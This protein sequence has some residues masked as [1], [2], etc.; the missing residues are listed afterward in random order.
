L[1]L[2]VAY[3][4]QC[5][6]IDRVGASFVD[7]LQQEEA[8][9]KTLLHEKHASQ[10][11]FMSANIVSEDTDVFVFCIA[12]VN[13]IGIPLYQKRGTKSPKVRNSN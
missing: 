4:E 2:F 10:H 8:N 11:G 3:G 6:K 9:T 13:E 12:F 5:W 1:V 7:E